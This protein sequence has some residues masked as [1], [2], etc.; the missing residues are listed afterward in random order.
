MTTTP[1]APGPGR[2][3]VAED[4]AISRELLM[5]QLRTLHRDAVAVNDGHQA[6]SA[7]R[8]GD[9]ALLLTDLE[10]PGMSGCDLARLVRSG[11]RRADAPIVLLTARSGMAGA[12]HAGAL[13]DEVLIKPAGIATLRTV[14]DKWIGPAPVDGVAA[15]REA[16]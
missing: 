13:V 4:N 8:A 9:F 10:M 3:L 14:L 12:E 11:A 15:L 5:H 6:I 16:P 2:I 1:A 7:W